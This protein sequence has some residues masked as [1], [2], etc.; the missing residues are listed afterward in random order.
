MVRTEEQ[1]RVSR[2]QAQPTAARNDTIPRRSAVK[3][4]IAWAVLFPLALSLE[5]A[6]AADHAPWWG[7]LAALALFGALG[8]TV[9]G[10]ARNK[11]WGVGAS[12]VASW[13][14]AAGV[15]ACPTTGH[16][17]MGLWWFGELGAS[18]ALVAM[19]AAVYARVRS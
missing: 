5:P 12:L 16:H 17:A 4:L 15:F 3:L 18:I 7:V 13:I 14:F 11:R 2:S 10:L 8:A 19:S 9:A 6:A 1:Q